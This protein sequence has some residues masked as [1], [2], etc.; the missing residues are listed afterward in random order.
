M[1][2]T[3]N[4]LHNQV[5]RDGLAAVGDE[6]DAETLVEVLQMFGQTMAKDTSCETLWRELS[7][8]HKCGRKLRRLFDP[9]PETTFIL[10]SP[11]DKEKQ[12]QNARA[13][14]G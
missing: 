14:V 9:I 1:A 3:T 4:Q 10:V 11:R 5:E 8:A 12:D 6:V 13:G 2:A 7:A